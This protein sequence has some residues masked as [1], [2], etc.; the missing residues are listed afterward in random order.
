[1]KRYD[2]QEGKERCFS[3]DVGDIIR[4]SRIGW[5]DVITEGHDLV[6]LNRQYAERNQLLEH[7]G[8]WDGRMKRELHCDASTYDIL[9]ICD[10]GDIT[11]RITSIER[12]RDGLPYSYRF[13]TVRVEGEA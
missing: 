3:L 4:V 7:A 10:T 9:R 1:M 11:L 8:A 2:A 13:E 5:N 6:L 12:V